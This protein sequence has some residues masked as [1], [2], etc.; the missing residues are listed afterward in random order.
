MEPTYSL[1]SALRPLQNDFVAARGER[2]AEMRRLLAAA[3]QDNTS[4]DPLRLALHKFAGSAGMLGFPKSR[5]VAREAEQF[6]LNN[7][8]VGPGLVELLERLAETLDAESGTVL[9]QPISPPES[10]AQRRSLATL[11]PSQISFGPRRG[12]ACI[13]TGER[14]FQTNAYSAELSAAG[15]EPKFVS[16]DSA[17]RDCIGAAVVL[18]DITA[19]GDG[20]SICKEIASLNRSPWLRILFSPGRSHFTILQ[21]AGSRAHRMVHRPF[22]LRSVLRPEISSD[23][24][25]KSRILS[26]E[27][28]PDYSRAL[29]A[30]L[31]PI[32]H[33]LK[34]ISRPEC[35][36][37]EL[38]EYR[39]EL[40]LLDWELPQ[41]SGP[42][43]ARIIRSDA[44]HELM[45]IIFCTGRKS[46]RDRRL[47][48]RAGADDFLTK[49]FA[50]DELV[51][52]IDVQ[53][54]R[55]RALRRR[56][57]A[58][59]LTELLNRSASFSALE[60]MLH[61]SRDRGH[62]VLVS[63]LDLD[64]FKKVNDELGHPT[65][66]RVLREIASHLRTNMRP[67]DLAGRIG[68]EELL[69]AMAGSNADAL[70]NRLEAIRDTLKIDLRGIEGEIM[71]ELTF[72]AGVAWFPQH[73]VAV[74]ELLKAADLALYQA[75]SSGRNRI[76]IAR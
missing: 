62:I 4:V 55:H 19:G 65:G 33:E 45:P 52:T 3:Q 66:D 25:I 60:D 22:E 10:G 61:V 17:V 29:E 51:E 56:L 59:G 15:F 27:D 67:G 46:Q 57:D 34:V 28:D 40:L 1:P 21:M 24:F 7:N 70:L 75:K 53:L 43:L 42:D 14:S 11:S 37:E 16:P 64:H 35:I 49:P 32:G 69:F 26:V 2:V 13:V 31:H 76:V 63:I 23:V 39:P 8:S 44:R 74:S 5:G 68:G 6:L 41:V 50:P 48:I 71:H 12:L 36:L 54:R 20:Y 30:I 73:G 58:D 47:A 38:V 18:I 9:Q 72:S